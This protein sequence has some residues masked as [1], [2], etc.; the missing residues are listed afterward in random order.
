MY[1]SEAGRFSRN[2]RIFN[3]ISEMVGFDSHVPPAIPAQSLPGMIVVVLGG[4]LGLTL[5]CPMA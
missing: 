4:W 1:H 5:R 3:L 2:S